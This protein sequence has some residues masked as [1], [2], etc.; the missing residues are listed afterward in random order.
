MSAKMSRPTVLESTLCGHRIYNSS[1]SCA[2]VNNV[3]LS[4][5]LGVQW[6]LRL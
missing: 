2:A 4:W 3:H 6:D 1:V 5:T